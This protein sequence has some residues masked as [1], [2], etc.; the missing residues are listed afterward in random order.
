MCDL[1]AYLIG[2]GGEEEIMKDI[3]ILDVQDDTLSMVNLFGEEKKLRAK[4][5]TINLVR[6]KLILEEV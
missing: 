3:Q 1:N 2:R 6:H 5:K 4:V